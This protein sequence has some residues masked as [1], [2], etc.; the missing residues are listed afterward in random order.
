MNTFP[1]LAALSRRVFATPASQTESKCTFSGAGL[2]VNKLH[3]S[4]DPEN[5]ERLLIRGRGEWLRIGRHRRSARGGGGYNCVV[6]A[7][8]SDTP[9]LR[10]L[11][12]VFV[13]FN[14]RV[15]RKAFFCFFLV[16]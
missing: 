9:L 6:A 10:W 16:Q 1:L 4:L 12:T 8:A 14:K 11:L 7:G 5:V 2:M 15:A 3:S 13:E